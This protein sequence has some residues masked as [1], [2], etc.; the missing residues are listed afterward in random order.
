[1]LFFLRLQKLARIAHRNG[2][3]E[4]VHVLNPIQLL[5]DRLPQRRSSIKR[6]INR[7]FGIRPKVV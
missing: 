1:L 4:A 6:R 3:R 5:F 7:D 2:A